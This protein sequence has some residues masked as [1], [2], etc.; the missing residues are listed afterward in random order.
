MITLE[1]C[2]VGI[3]MIGYIIVGI[4]YFLKGNYPWSVIWMSYGMANL[5]L[6]WAATIGK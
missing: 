6:I 1:N 3:C 4:S 2:I 5:G